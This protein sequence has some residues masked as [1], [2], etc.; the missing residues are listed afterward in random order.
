MLV[1]RFIGRMSGKLCSRTLM[2]SMSSIMAMSLPW[3]LCERAE[4]LLAAA[5]DRPAQWCAWRVEH[6]ET[7]D[8]PKPKGWRWPGA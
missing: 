3:I 5:L 4:S 2:K 6:P 8:R 1:S 7:G